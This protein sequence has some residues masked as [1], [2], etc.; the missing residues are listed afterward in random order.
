MT[1]IL[2]GSTTKDKWKNGTTVDD[3]LASSKS[4]QLIG[5]F[6]GLGWDFE[7]FL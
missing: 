6:F 1:G 3:G 2:R 7:S 4:L 5:N